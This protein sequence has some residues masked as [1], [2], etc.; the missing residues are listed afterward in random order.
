MPIDIKIEAEDLDFYEICRDPV[1]FAE[2]VNNFDTHEGEMEFELSWYQ[3]EFILD[4]SNYVSIRAG[5]A[6]GKTVSLVNLLNWILVFNVF[7]GDYITYHVPNKVH[8][9]P[10][11][12]GLIRSFR[13]NNF[14]KQFIQPNS[15]INSSDFRITLLNQASL[16]CRIAGTSGTGASVVGLHTPI[17]IVDESGFYPWVSFMEM[18][19]TLN[20]FTPGH[21]MIVAGVPDGRREKSVCYH[22]DQENSSYSKHHVQSMQ[23][24]RFTEKDLERAKEQ[25]GGVDSDDFIHHIFAEHGKP[26]FAIFDRTLFAINSDPVYKLTLNGLMLGSSLTEY[27]QKVNI[28]PP[29]PNRNAKVILGID[30]G[31]SEPTAIVILYLSELGRI[32][33]HG[34]IRLEKVSYP[35]QE[36]LIDLLDSKYN[37]SLIGIDKGAGGQGIS[38]VQHLL[39]DIEYDHKNFK[40]RMIPIDFGS[41][42]VIGIDSSGEEIKNKAKPLSISVLQE[43]S[44]NHK[45]VYSSTD[46]EMVSELERMTYVKN[47]SGEIVYRTLTQKGGQKGEDHF[48]SAL[49]CG[50]LAYYLQT[51]FMSFRAQKKTL[52]KPS[53]I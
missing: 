25:Y 30:L 8:L 40:K 5:R 23:N 44:N 28:F 48:T 38:V 33:F 6:S 53:W 31:Y 36:R 16:I 3:K 12:N 9:E 47:P 43:Y 21:R 2:F 42:I 10:V 22:C 27:Y 49:L 41:N 18:Q 46:L 32:H 7:P 14:L 50:I 17:V 39:E 11:W 24:P 34:R 45:I 29:V 37:P 26:V 52:M 13:T 4:F 51:D 15:G 20:T 1:L 35:I 19:P